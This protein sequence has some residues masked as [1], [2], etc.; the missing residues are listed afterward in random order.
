MSFVIA[1]IACST[2]NFST[3]CA[4]VTEAGLGEALSSGSW[5]VFAPTNR[6]FTKLGNTLDAVLADKPLLT[7]ILLFHAVEGEVFSTDL[8]CTARVKMA[9]GDESRTVCRRGS[10]FQKGAGNPRN[11]MPEII[12]ADIEACNGVIHVVDEVMLP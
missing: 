5:T 2:D 7:D 3:L 11:D 1:E 6:A 12:S 4:A 9:N 10:V 8:E